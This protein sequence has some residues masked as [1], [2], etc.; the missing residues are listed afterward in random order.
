VIRITF[1][2]DT[3]YASFV[4]SYKPIQDRI[5]LY[6]ELGQNILVNGVK[7]FKD[8]IVYKYVPQSFLKAYVEAWAKY[9]KSEG[10]QPQK[11]FLVIEEINRGNCAQI[12]GDLFQLLDRNSM[13]F[14][15]YPIQTDSDLKKYLKRSFQDI[16]IVQAEKIN[17]LYSN[18]Q[19]DLV[20]EVLEG[21]I[22]LLPNNLYIWATMNTSD[23]SLF[24]IDS[25]FKRRWEWKYMPISNA[26]HGW[27][28]EVGE[29]KYDW[30][31]VLEAINVKVGTTTNSEDKKL[32]YFF[33][34]PVGNRI[35]VDRFVSKVIFYLWNDVFK[36]YEFDD[37]IFN[38]GDGKLTFDKFYKKA[39][40]EIVVA[41]EKVV[42]FLQNLGVKPL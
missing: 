33:A 21:D 12:F 5:E 3:D 20:K 23:Q 28:I 29:N 31:T 10:N 18:N 32:G 25:A 7:V 19:R 1:H 4:G 17:D 38:D 41:I 27:Y 40:D 24:P 36:D 16:S 2:P 42:L 26:N 6:D 14:S 22:L 13:G 9:A 35:A 34:K 39:G 37:A 8:Q 15:D 30:W 11:Q